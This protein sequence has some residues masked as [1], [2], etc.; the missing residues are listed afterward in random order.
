MRR[1]FCRLHPPEP[2]VL[3]RRLSFVLTGLPPLP[4]LRESYLRDAEGDPSAAYSTLIDSLLASPHFGEHFSRHWMDV[5]RYTDTYGYESDNPA[6][7]A[8]EYRD[9]LI[10][11]FNRDV[12]FDQMLREQWPAICCRNLGSSGVRF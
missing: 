1:G 9:Y 11:E 2:E 5:V 3:L 12:P 8:Y 10:R 4:A 6:N 7:G